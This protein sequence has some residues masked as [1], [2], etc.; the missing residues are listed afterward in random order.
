MRRRRISVAVLSIVLFACLAWAQ[1]SKRGI[2]EKDIFNFVWIGQPEVSPDGS[3][4]VFVR[5]TVN[6][7]RDGYDTQ[8]YIMPTSGGEPAR[9]TSGKRDQSPKWSPD[10][11]YLAFV[12]S[13]E[14]EQGAASGGGL[15]G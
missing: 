1:G 6:D 9:L 15:P 10:G 13:P 12:R 14:V 5:V 3:R 7:R 4:V 8:L 11:K 2:T